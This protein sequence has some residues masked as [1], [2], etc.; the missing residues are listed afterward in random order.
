MKNEKTK[1]TLASV[2]LTP[3]SWFYEH[4]G[5]YGP[6]SGPDA[7][8]VIGNFWKK[9][10]RNAAIGAGIAVVG[11]AAFGGEGGF[12]GGSSEIRTDSGVLYTRSDG[13]TIFSGMGGYDGNNPSAYIG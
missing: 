3:G 6:N 8:R 2:N 13:S 4:S 12:G 1:Y 10:G 5:D 11:L 7:G 9:A